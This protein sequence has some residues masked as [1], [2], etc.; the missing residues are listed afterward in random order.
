MVSAR[1]RGLSA[2]QRRALAA[3]AEYWLEHRRA[4]SRLELAERLG[5][6][7]PGVAKVLRPL[8]A[9]GLVTWIKRETRTIRIAPVPRADQDPHR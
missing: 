8:A 6:T 3:V 5:M 2:H 1:L 4:P 9:R 7:A